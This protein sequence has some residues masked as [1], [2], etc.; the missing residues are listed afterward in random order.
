V[1]VDWDDE[2]RRLFSGEGAPREEAVEGRLCAAAESF[3]RE[4][5]PNYLKAAP[6]RFLLLA[7]SPAGRWDVNVVVSEE[8]GWVVVSLI[9][10]VKCPPGRRGPVLEFL[11]RVN[12]CLALGSYEMDAEAGEVRFRV[13]MDAEPGPE[14]LQGFLRKAFAAGFGVFFEHYVPL[15]QVM[16]GAEPRG[17]AEGAPGAGGAGR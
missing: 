10:P 2:L 11:N 13:G 5:C 3:L 16:F 7:D 1:A 4:A 14:A 17:G 6:G 9:F 12:W 15:L 8:H